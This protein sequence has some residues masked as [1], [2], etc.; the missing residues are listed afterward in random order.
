MKKIYSIMFVAILTA[1][2]LTSCDKKFNDIKTEEGKLSFENFEASVYNAE[3]VIESR[4]A[5]VDVNT[6]KV[7]VT[8]VKSGAVAG[9]WTYSE[10]PEVAT[11]PLGDYKVQVYNAELQDAA[12][13]SPYFYGE[14][15]FTIV[16][17][18]ITKVEPIV[19][20]L[21]NLKVSIKY[22]DE[23][24]YAIGEGNDVK[25]NV[26]VGETSSLDFVYGEERAGYFKCNE[27]NKTLVATFSGTVEGC[28]VSEYKVIS[29]VAAGQHRIITFSLNTAP[30]IVD[31]YGYISTMGASLNASVTTVDLLRD[32]IVEEELVQP[33]DFMTLSESELSFSMKAGSKNVTVKSSSEWT[34]VSNADWCTV[35]PAKGAA[36]ESKLTVSVTDNTVES[37]RTA[38][39]TVTM[40]D[41]QREITVKQAAY[42][43]QP[44]VAAPTITSVSEGI[45]LNKECVITTTSQVKLEIQAEAGVEKLEVKIISNLLSADE[46]AGMGLR[47][48]FDLAEPGDEEL[49]ANLI[50]LG[51][52]VGAEVKGV[53]DIITFE[54]STFM[55]MLAQL[56]SDVHTFRLTVTDSVG[57]VTSADLILKVE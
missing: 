53:K 3:N 11:L 52:P 15:S 56:G 5:S 20:K 13:D 27:D 16:K 18:D 7:V 1:I 17:N 8:N 49:K 23:L 31:E 41:I 38:V 37:E 12:W 34:A 4:A 36:P 33:D 25:V 57:Q 32:I 26:Q 22:S 19:C 30:E 42:S 35:S 51:F 14:Q 44:S 2:S 50:S 24:R 40:G 46:L 43:E 21:N 55:G 28:Y 45:E 6:F 29:D 10:L 9:S 48:E 54:I 47:Q 39:I